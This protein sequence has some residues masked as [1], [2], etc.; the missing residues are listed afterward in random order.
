METKLSRETVIRYLKNCA[1]YGL[2][3]YNPKKQMIRSGQRNIK[4]AN[5]S[6]QIKVICL[7]TNQV[8]DSIADAYKWLGY[9]KDGHSIQDQC[10]GKTLTAGKHPITKEKLKWMYYDE[11]L[12][13]SEVSA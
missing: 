6:N 12:K 2:C 1:K 13:C 7:N 5:L 4:Y 9:N 10:N 3:D 11:Y 8:F